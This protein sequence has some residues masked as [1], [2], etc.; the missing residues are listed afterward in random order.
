MRSKCG[1]FGLLHWSVSCLTRATTVVATVKAMP[2]KKRKPRTIRN[3]YTQVPSSIVPEIV[4]RPVDCNSILKGVRIKRLA[5]SFDSSARK[6]ELPRKYPAVWPTALHVLAHP[7]FSLENQPIEF[8]SALQRW[9]TSK[10]S[11]LPN[12]PHKY[13]VLRQETIN[14]R[15]LPLDHKYLRQNSSIIQI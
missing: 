11:I 13:L 8:V 1:S 10:A 2:Q 15:K 5:K 14:Q 12:H 6:R 7:I 3:D 9:S 4:T